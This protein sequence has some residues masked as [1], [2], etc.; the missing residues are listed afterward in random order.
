MNR[1]V[2]KSQWNG[3]ERH[4]FIFEGRKAVVTIPQTPAPDQPWIWETKDFDK[5]HQVEMTMLEKGWHIVYYDVGGMFGCPQAISCMRIFHAYLEGFYDLMPQAAMFG[6]CAGAL[7]AFNYAYAYPK[8]VAALCL[9]SPV[10]DI[11]SWPGGKGVGPGSPADWQL[12]M[13]V[14]GLSDQTAWEFKGSPL[15]NAEKV[16]WS[17]IPVVIIYRDQDMLVPFSENS[18]VL[19]EKYSRAKGG[20]KVVVEAGSGH[21]DHNLKNPMEVA[22]FI[23]RNARFSK[24]DGAAQ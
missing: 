18:E 22:E 12:C 5:F 9:D 13:A 6:F 1:N 14:Y 24:Q 21:D 20:I 8:K 3:Y 11:R 16:A 10:L 2:T 7:Y 15:D 4:D 17:G 23:I 19:I